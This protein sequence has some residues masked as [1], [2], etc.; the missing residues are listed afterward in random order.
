M[1]PRRRRTSAAQHHVEWMQLVDISGPF[2]SLS[3]LS[4]VFPQNLDAVDPDIGGRYRQAF[5][6]WQAN[7]ELRR[8]DAAIEAA[9]VDF[10]L[11]DVLELPP[12]FIADRQALGDGY[13][14][15]LPE[16]RVVLQPDA[17]IARPSERP[18]VLVQRYGSGVSL[19]KPLDERGLHASP[20]ERMRI[21]LTRTGVRSGLLTNGVEWM[22]VHAPA[23]RTATFV[24]WYSNLLAEEQITLRA[25]RS[26][27]GAHR[28]F[29]VDD[30]E[31]LDG[32]FERSR[33][34]E[35]EVTDQLGIQ[36]RRAVELLVAAYD[37]ADR[38]VGG[39]LLAHVP[40]YRLYEA[41]LAV[42][43][44]TIFLLAA[45]A[46]GLF[47]DDGPWVESYAVTP[48]RAQL[49]AD[50]DR[51]GIE[52][53]ERRFDA[54]PRLLATFRAVH[55][56]VAHSRVRMPGYGGGLFDPRRYPFLGGDSV[57]PRISN[58]AILHILD[59]L[60][61]LEVDVPGGRE[62]RP[63]S[64]RALGV[65]Q[66]GHVYEGLLDH[67]AIR[68]DAPALGLAGTAKKEPEIALRELEQK[69]DEGE[70]ALLDSLVE[71]TGR[72]RPALRKGLAAEPE[73]ERVARLRSACDHDSALV[74]R[75]LPFSGIVRDDVFGDPLVF[76]EGRVYVTTSPF[77][78]S[79]GTHYTPPSLTE[80]IVR[81][82]LEPVVYRGP[83][84]GSPIE[85]WQL[86]CP[87]ELLDLKV[88]DIAMGSAAFLVAACRYLAARLVEA[89]EQHPEGAP[90]DAGADPEERELTARRLV[91]ERCLYGVDKNPLA[92][93]IAKVS[94]W[95]TTMRRDR[96]FTF[97]DHA[98][99]HG[100]S[101]LGVTSV[102][103]LERLTLTPAN[104][105]SVLLDSAREVIRA[106]LAEVR[107]L[108]ERIEATD[109]VDIRDVEEKAV[110]LGRTEER[111]GALN[112]V[113]DLLVGAE[114][115]DA[116]GRGD[117]RTTMEA[118]AD[119][120]CAC[121]EAAP[122]HRR[123]SLLLPLE[124]RAGDA[125]L[126]GRAPAD[127]DALNPFHWVLE[128]PEVFQ[129]GRSGFDAIVGNPP[130]LGGQKITGTLGEPF[131]EY[132]IRILA[133]GRRGSADLV[134]Y[135]FLRARQLLA[136]RGAFGLLATDTIA[137][138]DTRQIGLAALSRNG[139]T[140]IRANPTSEWPGEAGVQVAHVWGVT[141]GWEGTRVVEGLV[142]TSIL[143]SLMPPGRVTGDPFPLA[144][145]AGDVFQGSIVLG[146]GFL[147]EPDDA[148]R[149]IEAN[150]SNADVLKPYLVAE[151]LTKQPRQAPTRWAINFRDWAADAARGYGDLWPIVDT[152]V[153]PEREKNK[154]RVRRE[155]WWQFAEPAKG[156]YNA[157]AEF[158][159]VLVGPAVSK[160]WFVVWRPNGW[161]Y[162]H[163]VFVFTIQDDGR[164]AVLSSTFHD[165]WA[166]KHSSTRGAGLNYSPTDCYQ[167]FPFPADCRPLNDIGARY[168]TLRQET[169]LAEDQGLTRV[170]NR[171]H[172]HPEDN[173]RRIMELR[174][175]RRELD[176]AVTEA[177]G[178][179]GIELDHGFRSTPLGVRYTISDSART[180]V[181]DRLLELNQARYADEVK[182][183]LNT[184][185][186]G[187]AATTASIGSQLTL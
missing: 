36:A 49:Q 51:Y 121:L 18:S 71:H 184:K 10:V 104:D 96:P 74:N 127:P 108:R 64:F 131:R 115:E 1:S 137:Q 166:R 160:Y 111:V 63:L 39:A 145:N 135:F 57:V 87:S 89:W 69:R 82:A 47:P 175:L 90:P 120:I 156:L 9:F 164:A 122:G 84:E 98:L 80:P 44:R 151:E 107:V 186:R 117:A 94:M 40:E 152:K 83:S 114:L 103:Q 7:R 78:R 109:A 155:R 176:I 139:V 20:A 43:M 106:T 34:D 4:E 54:W 180:D 24:T 102:D 134:A 140:L 172:E 56:G 170:Y 124:A 59:A 66:I 21:L 32:M 35:R 118:S 23:E 138:G 16:H 79:T 158:P 70:D 68:A 76:R 126:S 168:L 19:E 99:R 13:A 85:E 6:E 177:Y 88:C 144:A 28:L 37:R 141:G 123:D 179:T 31:T 162:S 15:R 154:R 60:Q 181:L 142:V 11:A 129:T 171:V 146:S 149:L 53:L 174:E 50:S 136:D 25:F 91:A 185:R 77:R 48:L 110:L 3:V 5:A 119:E 75:V 95:L 27:L 55:D 8:P 14:A 26:L 38:D 92:V 46:R 52:V 30:A 45:E 62:R 33:D 157:I 58:R 130:F 153:R 178:W 73:A 150:A 159:R 12:E 187:K 81:H 61:T 128:F 183:G 125:L 93:E 165:S 147:L 132:I 105:D 169:L 41:S 97:L 148:Q 17:A 67:T 2:I 72:S 100:D 116:S 101:L 42:V 167:N 65:E 182:Q 143:P 163:K 133:D 113:G 29:G 112:A 22:L 173:S 161:V 86:K